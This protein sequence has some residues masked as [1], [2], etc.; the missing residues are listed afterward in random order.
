MYPVIFSVSFSYGVFHLIVTA[1]L[2]I[3]TISSFFMAAFRSAG[4]PSNIIW[5]HYPTVGKGVLENYTFCA[6]CAKPKPPRA[7]HCRSCR[8][9]VLDMDHHCPFIGNCV[10]AANHRHFVAFLISVVSSCAYVAAMALYAGFHLWPP[11][12]YGT[13]RYSGIKMDAMSVLQQLLAAFASSALLLS[14]RGLVLIYLAFASFSVEIGLSVLLW[15]QLSYIYE[16]H[17]YI[18]ILSSQNG[19]HGER[20]CQNLL[21]FFGCPYSVSRFLLGPAYAAKLQETSGSKLL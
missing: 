17:T 21:R 15:Q 2:S 16:G 12:A 18:N 8:M 5:G 10:G 1:I 3:C 19:E 9:C 7:H 13:L 20:G 11:L 14:T 6:Y 4:S